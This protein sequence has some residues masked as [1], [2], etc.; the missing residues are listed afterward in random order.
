MISQMQQS[1]FYVAAFLLPI[2]FLA[3]GLYLCIWVYRDAQ[4]RGMNGALWV[5]IVLIGNI[6]GLLIYL[7]VREGVTRQYPSPA[8]YPIA[9]YCKY[10]GNLLPSD[11]RFCHKCGKEQ[12]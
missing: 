2:A 10:C 11:A 4:Q 6:V 12:T 9:Q 3:I 7:G 1:T 8:P 5:V